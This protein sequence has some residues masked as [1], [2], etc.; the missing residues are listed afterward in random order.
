VVRNR[1][2]DDRAAFIK[3]FQDALKTED[4]QKP[5]QDDI[6]RRKH[7]F[8][9]VLREVQGLGDGSDKGA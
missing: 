3:P 6:S 5:I 4:G 7:I 8:S 9:M 2:D 1:S